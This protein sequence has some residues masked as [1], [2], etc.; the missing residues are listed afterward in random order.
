MVRG[1]AKQQ[2]QEK[3][4]AKQ[5]ILVDLTGD[6]FPVSNELAWDFLLNKHGPKMICDS[7][8]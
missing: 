8:T 7:V 4:A 6:F 5:A 3:N 2:A 1:H